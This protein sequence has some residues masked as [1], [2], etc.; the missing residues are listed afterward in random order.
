MTGHD[1]VVV[2]T[3]VGFLASTDAMFR[4]GGYD[5]TESHYGVGGAWGRDRVEH[6][7]GVVF[8]W[9]DR[10]RGADANLEANLRAISVETADNAPGA[11]RDIARWTPRQADALV[12]LIAW[13]CSPGAHAG[14]PA[15]WA[16]HQHGI[17]ARIVPDSKPGRRGI[18]YH[19]QGI[20]PWRVSGGERWSTSRGKECPG[21]QR[22]RQLVDEIVPAVRA[23]LKGDDMPLTKDDVRLC[24]TGVKV[25]HNENDP[26]PTEGPDWTPAEAMAKADTKLDELVKA[27]RAAVRRDTATQSMIRTLVEAFGQTA[28]EGVRDAFRVGISDLRRALADLDVRIEIGD[29][30]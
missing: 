4:R 7:D 16:C 6:L 1:L 15:S 13:E 2:H 19:R 25:V 24:W 11:A 21:P 20:D 10:A 3:M 26:T 12:D 14:C 30:P 5:G 17:P 27:S 29:Q 8:Q 22:I 9:Q 28:P 18:A 23:R